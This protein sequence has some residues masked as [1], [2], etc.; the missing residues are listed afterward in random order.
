M[1]QNP[2]VWIQ[3]SLGA[4]CIPGRGGKEENI[5]AQQILWVRFLGYR[6]LDLPAWTMLF[7]KSVSA[8]TTYSV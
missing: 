6:F 5:S 2:H 4:P 7:K 8:S 3:L 1:E